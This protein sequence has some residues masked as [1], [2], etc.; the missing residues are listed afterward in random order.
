MEKKYSGKILTDSLSLCEHLITFKDAE[1]GYADGEFCIIIKYNNAE[2]LIEFVDH[3]KDYYGD[4]D[5]DGWVITIMGQIWDEGF[6]EITEEQEK[7]LEEA[8]NYWKKMNDNDK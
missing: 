7:F 6:D 3:I 4:Y 2:D 5:G 1:E 8:Y